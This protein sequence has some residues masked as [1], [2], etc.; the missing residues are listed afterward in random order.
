RL[1]R[2][3][4]FEDPALAAA[5]FAAAWIDPAA[6]LRLMDRRQARAVA[7]IAPDFEADQFRPASPAPSKA[8]AGGVVRGSGRSTVLDA[9]EGLPASASYRLAKSTR[10]LPVDG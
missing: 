7:G 10:P 3:P 6:R 9:M 1:G 2:L 4:R 8:E 5:L